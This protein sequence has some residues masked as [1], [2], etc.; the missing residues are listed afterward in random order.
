M[1]SSPAGVET[2]FDDLQLCS[3]GMAIIATSAIIKNER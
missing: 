1:T 3:I 2:F